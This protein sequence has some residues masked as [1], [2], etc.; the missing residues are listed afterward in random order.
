MQIL[1]YIQRFIKPIVVFIKSHIELLERNDSVSL[2]YYSWFIVIRKIRKYQRELEARCDDG[3]DTTNYNDVV[4]N[5]DDEDAEKYEF[6]I[7]LLRKLLYKWDLIYSD[8]YIIGYYLDPR[9]IDIMGEIDEDNGIGKFYEAL[10][11]Y[12]PKVSERSKVRE[13]F[14]KFRTK[15]GS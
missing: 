8:I 14:V 1:I 6:Y 3:V 11:R 13:E 2:V 4:E 5:L 9:F 10:H 15:A 7:Y 12:F